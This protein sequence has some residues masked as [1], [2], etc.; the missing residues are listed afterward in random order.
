MV[1]GKFNHDM[2]QKGLKCIDC[3]NVMESKD[4]SDLSLPSIKSCVECHS[5]KG[6][7]DSRC[8]RCHTYHNSRPGTRL[9][10][11]SGPTFAPNK[12]GSAK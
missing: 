12:A 11:S 7:I 9:P 6:G 3:H 8:V 5:P 2:H 4:T 10:K 1:H